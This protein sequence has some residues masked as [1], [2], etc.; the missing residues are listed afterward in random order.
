MQR[1]SRTGNI[2]QVEDG[3][4]WKDKNRCKGKQTQME[5]R[6]RGMKRTT[7]ILIRYYENSKVGLRM[8]E[9]KITQLRL[10]EANKREREKKIHKKQ[11]IENEN[12][13]YSKEDIEIKKGIEHLQKTDGF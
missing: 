7:D 13:N 9:I 6:E 8:Q 4:R 12:A 2:A 1:N 3:I 11:E 5:E 10:H